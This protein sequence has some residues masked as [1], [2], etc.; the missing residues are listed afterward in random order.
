MVPLH[1][2]EIHRW[3]VFINMENTTGYETGI[4]LYRL[5]Y[6]AAVGSMDAS[7]RLLTI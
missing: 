1:V 7:R 3:T 4:G 5:R 2:P 6:Q